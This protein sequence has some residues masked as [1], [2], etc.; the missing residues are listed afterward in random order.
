MNLEDFF[1]KNELGSYELACE[2]KYFVMFA[3]RIPCEI[4]QWQL[5]LFFVIILPYDLI[6][7]LGFLNAWNRGIGIWCGSFNLRIIL[8]Y[9]EYK[10]VCCKL[11]RISWL[12]I[13]LL[14]VEASLFWSVFFFFF[15]LV[16]KFSS[17]FPHR[18]FCFLEDTWCL[19]LQIFSC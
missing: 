10:K 19:V 6:I 12:W 13:C 9:I 8:A 3:L 1:W 5:M 2:N 7:L 16:F 14:I 4:N 11:W 15:F 17:F 18:I